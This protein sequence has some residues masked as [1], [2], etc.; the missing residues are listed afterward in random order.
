MYSTKPNGIQ[1]RGRLYH[2]KAKA[3]L[4]QTTPTQSTGQVTT[5][6]PNDYPSHDKVA[7]TVAF[8]YTH[9]HSAGHAETMPLADDTCQGTLFYATTHF[10]TPRCNLIDWLTHDNLDWRLP[11]PA[12]AHD[13]LQPIAPTTPVL[14]APIPL[15]HHVSTRRHTKHAPHRTERLHQASRTT[16]PETCDKTSR[17]WSAHDDIALTTTHYSLRQ[18]YPRD[19]T[20]HVLTGQDPAPDKSEPRKAASTTTQALLSPRRH[21]STCLVYPR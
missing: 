17:D 10:F 14:T 9:R 11:T 18:R 8:D 16:C 1:R 7:H 3:T 15:C 4:S 2:S 6:A 21:F 5:R 20:I 12:S 19:Y 13:F